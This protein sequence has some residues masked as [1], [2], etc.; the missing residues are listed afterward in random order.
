MWTWCHNLVGL[1]IKLFWAAE[2]SGFTRERKNVGDWETLGLHIYT[3]AVSRLDQTKK[4]YISPA[5]ILTWESMIKER[6]LILKWQPFSHA[7]NERKTLGS[8]Y[9]SPL[10]LVVAPG[11]ILDLLLLC[12][13]LGSPT[14]KGCSRQFCFILKRLQVCQT[15]TTMCSFDNLLRFTHCASLF[16]PARP[17]R[18][19]MCSVHPPTAIVHAVF[20][21]RAAEYLCA[22]HRWHFKHTLQSVIATWQQILHACAELWARNK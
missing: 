14:R 9:P 1:G 7:E 19:C 8:R 21:V 18:N 5:I 20:V 12:S 2:I 17:H 6:G 3:R 16:D 13:Y 4:K 10:Q 15:R 11:M 22:C